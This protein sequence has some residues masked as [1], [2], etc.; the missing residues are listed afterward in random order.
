MSEMA[1]DSRN[2]IERVAR[3]IAK[4]RLISAWGLEV[5]EFK[6]AEL[7]WPKDEKAWR[8]YKHNPVAAI[9]IAFDE[10]RAA[11]EAMREPG[12]QMIDKGE[13]ALEGHKDSD[14]SSNIDGDRE[15]YEYYTSG[16]CRDMWQAMID[17]ALKP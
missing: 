7:R 5:G 17:K 12:K 8:A 6:F 10:A 14:Y 15:S 2:I 11:I 9:D 4:A 3:A 16:A 1:E 13:D